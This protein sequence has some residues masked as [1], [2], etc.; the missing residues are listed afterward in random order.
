[1]WWFRKKADEKLFELLLQAETARSEK[2]RHIDEKRADIELRKLELEYANLELVAEQRRKDAREKAE[3]RE[4]RKE[5]VVN[6]RKKVE[7]NRAA[8][9]AGEGSAG[10]CRVCINQ[11]EPSLT[12]AE[13][14][15][16]IAGHRQTTEVEYN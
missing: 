4:K 3:L 1:M 15:W 11:S 16:H 2:S 12:S 6:A 8:R 5:W 13:I 14:A 7:A 10:G 9:A